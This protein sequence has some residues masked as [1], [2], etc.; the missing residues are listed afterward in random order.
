MAI[1]IEKLMRQHGVARA[2][3][4]GTGTGK[5]M[6][7][8]RDKGFS[9]DGIDSSPVAAKLSGALVGSATDIPFEP[10]R[11][12]CVIGISVL[13]HLTVSEGKRFVSEAFRVLRAEGLIFLVTPN[14]SSPLRYVLGRNWFGYSDKTHISFYTPRK[15][16]S[17]LLAGGFH[18]VRF[19]FR[20][21]SDALD[22]PLPGYFKRLPSIG[23]RLLNFLLVSTPLALARD[24]VW[25]AGQKGELKSVP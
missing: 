2:L 10:D 12:D 16:R 11:F 5:L 1:A 8:L 9:V 15:M 23:R 3:E 19:T 24:S 20:I 25:V 17:L 13:E 7:H 14:F 6:R 18:R 22:W 21:D 4:V